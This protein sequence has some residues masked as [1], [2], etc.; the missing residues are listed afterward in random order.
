MNS[1]Y[2]TFIARPVW[3]QR[4]GRNHRVVQ[5]LPL[6]NNFKTELIWVICK[7]I[8][9]TSKSC[10]D[11]QPKYQDFTQPCVSSKGPYKPTDRF[12]LR[13]TSRPALSSRTE[14]ALFRT[15]RLMR[16]VDFFWT[17]HWWQGIHRIWR[18]NS[19]DSNDTRYCS[20]W[21]SQKTTIQTLQ[22]TFQQSFWQ[23]QLM[24]MFMDRI[25]V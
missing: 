8:L 10:T 17:R 19:N 12:T 3:P 2:F 11:E 5:Y 14:Y 1:A 18:E 22:F 4:A 24:V 23:V 6:A 16:L 20:S 13:L 21:L 9:I 7:V 15:A 25:D